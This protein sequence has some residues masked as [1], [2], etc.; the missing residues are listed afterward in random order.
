MPNISRQNDSTFF[1]IG[2]RHRPT[3]VR[4]LGRIQYDRNDQTNKEWK[5][6]GQ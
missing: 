5:D 6:D 4:H 1:H 3:S 2:H